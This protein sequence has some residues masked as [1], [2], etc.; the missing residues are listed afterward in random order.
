MSTPPEQYAALRALAHGIN[1][2]LTSAARNVVSF[3]KLTGARSFDTPYGSIVF[4]RAQPSIVLPPAELLLWAQ[5]HMEWEVIPE[6][7]ETVPATVRP[8][9]VKNLIGTAAKPG[10]FRIVGDQVID[11]ADGSV[12]EWARVEPAG[13]DIVTM[14]MPAEAKVEAV[15]LVAERLPQIAAIA[16]VES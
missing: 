4:T 10:R 13:Q 14:R 9:L 2:A 3:R 6:H 1:E 15:R 16:E 11:T 12:V 8:S 5:E 7:Q